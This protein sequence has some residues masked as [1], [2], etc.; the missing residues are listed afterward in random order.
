MTPPQ[1]HWNIYAPRAL[2]LPA[3]IHTEYAFVLIEPGF[4][5]IPSTNSYIHARLGEESGYERKEQTRA[6]RRAFYQKLNAAHSV[7]ILGCGSSS[8]ETAGQLATYFNIKKQRNTWNTWN[9]SSS[10]RPPNPKADASAISRAN[11]IL[12]PLSRKRGSALS[13]DP[14]TPP[15]IEVTLPAPGPRLAKTITYLSGAERLL[16]K[17]PP[18]VGKK[19]EKQLKKLGVHGVH[20]IRQLS[21]TVNTNGSTNCI[22]N[23]DMTL[24]S[25]FLIS[26][27][28]VYPN[29]RHLPA[30][31]LDEYK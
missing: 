7:L 9:I 22:L 2:V 19:A 21:S 16:P 5:D 27:T 14:I 3:L 12:F 25:D 24:T 8:C 30:F 20:N 23:N 1:L 29:T 26:A 4:S 13:T 31:M 18:A 28:G 17:L 11:H 15:T 10:T 6:E